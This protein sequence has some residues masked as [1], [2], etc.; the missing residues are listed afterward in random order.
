MPGRIRALAVGVVL[1]AALLVAGGQLGG[2]SANPAYRAQARA[3]LHGRLALAQVPEAIRHDFVWSAERG[4]QQVWGL[5]VAMWQA[6]FEL[7]ARAVHAA[8]F[9]DRVAMLVFIALAIAAAIRAWWR[10]D[11]R[12]TA[13][14]TI[15]IAA[16]LPAFVTLLRGRVGVY[17]EAAAYAYAGALL[18]LAQTQ[19]HAD[20]PRRA[21]YWILLAA[22][23][24]VGFIRPTAWFYGLATAIVA[25]AHY[26]GAY[27]R[28]AIATVA[29]GAALF[30]AG[31]AALYAT[32]AARFGSGFE[33][34]HRLNLEGLPGNLYATRFGYPFEHA[35]LGQATAE[36][37]G[38]LFDRPEKHVHTTFYA[39][40]LHVGQAD[41]PRWREYYFS[42]YS[43][44]YV[45]VLVA[46][47]VLGVLAW[48]RRD[49]PG[50]ER[51]LVAWA[52]LG[53][54]PLFA[55]YLRSPSM[56]SRYQLDL[57]PAFVA[58]V[59]VAWRA[60]AHRARGTVA[61]GVLGAAW[62]ACIVLA[63]T[64]PRIGPDVVG[65]AEAAAAA[66][67]IA[68][69]E[70]PPHELPAAWDL[71]DPLIATETDTVDEFARCRDEAG[72]PVDPDAAPIGGET[73]I[74]GER[75]GDGEPWRVRETAVAPPREPTTSAACELPEPAC[76]LEPTVATA[77]DVIAAYVP[78]PA[79]YLNLFRWDL[80]TGQVPSATFAWL[81]DPAFVELDVATLDG[82]P[83]DW[84]RDVRV[85]I[86]LVHLHLVARADLP[87]GAVRLR[88]E[89]APLPH[90]LAVV[91][92]AFGPEAE[93]ANVHT[94]FSVRR[95]R[96]RP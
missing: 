38:A 73:C 33:F 62:L 70:A 34:G 55:F 41:I 30:V 26:I 49:R 21:R 68:N 82:A 74:V 1:A 83:A 64:A 66:D 44:G 42:T 28:R 92:F 63:R 54:A 72:E 31:G 39:R 8:P 88:F 50:P 79:L 37:L 46:G 12:V 67:E 9:P 29:L 89:G 52:V 91:F 95:V 87:D 76:A 65:H 3:L 93:L 77:G 11:D 47:L 27:G 4:V 51:W 71:A 45:P 85:A 84:D 78:E 90:G 53:G 16:L 81:Q 48:R 15:V 24:A 86:G 35:S 13:A 69:A 5:G 61:L 7:A 36:E 96:W 10:R 60:F 43:W 14:G 23:G 58:L 75:D 20:E 59:V 19:R 57:A 17:E 32:N 40:G 22:A 80:A 94:R 6:P 56:S 2:Y 25:T 18:L